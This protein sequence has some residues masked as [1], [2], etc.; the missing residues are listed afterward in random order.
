[1]KPDMDNNFGVDLSILFQSNI[2][3]ANYVC[4]SIS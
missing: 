4:R 2:V 1:M 3:G